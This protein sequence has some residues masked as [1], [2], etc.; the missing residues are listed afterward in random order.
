MEPNIGDKVVVHYLID[1][2][3]TI[4]LLPSRLILAVLLRRDDHAPEM[5]SGK[6]GA[7]PSPFS[8]QQPGHAKISQYRKSKL[9]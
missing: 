5:M 8:C 2:S 3:T 1:N 6:K 4:I 9:L 7:G